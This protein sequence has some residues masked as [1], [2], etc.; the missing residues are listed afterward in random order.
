MW[1][2]YACFAMPLAAQQL[3]TAE[4]RWSDSFVAW[5]LYAL[6]PDTTLQQ[7]EEILAGE[8]SL[9]WLPVREDWSDWEYKLG[10]E[11]GTIK[12]R[13]RNDPTQWEL[14]A[15]NGTIITMRTMWGPQDLTEW[16]VTDNTHTVELR[17][18]WKNQLDEW[19]VKD[20]RWGSYYLYTLHQRDP[21]S[22]AI[23]DKME[24]TIST[25]MKLALLFL[26]LYHSTPRL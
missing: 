8:L 7:P 14:R 12:Q 23:E 2:L 20:P 5:Q 1:L 26:T 4:T 15:Y 21:R 10:N 6:D 24:A 18:R 11:R 16:R 25:E 22:W 3:S 17:S 9:R 19:W 13:W